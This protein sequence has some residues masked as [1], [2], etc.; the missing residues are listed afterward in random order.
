MTAPYS[1]H[2]CVAG[3]D[4]FGHPTTSPTVSQPPSIA[5]TATPTV[6]PLPTP[7][8]VPL[9]VPMMI[10]LPVPTAM[11]RPVPTGGPVPVTSAVPLPAPTSV[12]LTGRPTPHASSRRDHRVL[13]SHL[14]AL[15]ART[16]RRLRRRRLARAR[17]QR[18]RLCVFE[19]TA[20]RAV[21]RGLG[22]RRRLLGVG[23]L[24]AGRRRTRGRCAIVARSARLSV[25]LL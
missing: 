21:A 1:D 14:S 23:W 17:G 19:V 22:S 12:S 25:R 8:T 15:V 20:R 7:T 6:M 10:P 9:P 3:G 13:G 4:V 16:R 2:L 24:E 11:P 18:R 5:P